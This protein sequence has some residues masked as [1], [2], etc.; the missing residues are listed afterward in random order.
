MAKPKLNLN[1]AA[2]FKAT[3][4]I[5]VPGGRDAAVEFIFKYRD[6]EEFKEFLD[7]LN[8]VEGAEAPQKI[9]VMMDIASGW[10]LDEPFDKTSVDK[11]LRLYM[12]APQAVIDTY[13]SEMTGARVKN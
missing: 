8:G 4:T 9:D 11:M 7:T 1:P 13:V 2:T 5:P 3:V 10:D 12:G 6:R